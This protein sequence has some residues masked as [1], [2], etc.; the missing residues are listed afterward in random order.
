MPSQNPTAAFVENVRPEATGKEYWDARNPG[1]G[2]RV[3]TS[4]AK[5]WM[6]FYRLNG[7]VIRETLGKY[8]TLGPADARRLARDRAGAVQAGID[9]RKPKA[10]E[11][12][13]VADLAAAFMAQH[14]RPNNRSRRSQ[15]A[16]LQMHVVSRWG[17]L[18]L[19]RVTKMDVAKML[20]EVAVKQQDRRGGKGRAGVASGGPVAAENVLEVLRAMDNW[21][22]DHDLAEAKPALRARPPVRPTARDRVLTDDE[23]RAVWRAALGLGYLFGHFTRRLA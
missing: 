12:D 1:F 23:V 16:Q 18:P 2:L 7:K 17:D 3:G 15:E 20:Q 22:I 6:M 21:A 5:S 8:R 4:G 13:T 11:A 19:G 9:H 14:C 10:A